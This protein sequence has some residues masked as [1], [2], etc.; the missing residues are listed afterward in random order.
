MKQ[1]LNH[2]IAEWGLFLHLAK[3][4]KYVLQV[5]N[6]SGKETFMH[7][8][9]IEID[10]VITMLLHSEIKIP[11]IDLS[12][13]SRTEITNFINSNIT[14][15]IITRKI[16]PPVLLLVMLEL[17][18]KAEFKPMIIVF[19]NTHVKDFITDF[20]ERILNN[21]S[22][23]KYYRESYTIV[24]NILEPNKKNF[25]DNALLRSYKEAFKDL[26]ESSYN[27]L[28]HGIDHV[29][30][31]YKKALHLNIK[32]NLNI[33]KDEILVASLFH[34]IFQDKDRDK[35]HILAHDWIM[36][37]V[38]PMI[39]LNDKNKQKRIALAIKEHRSTY[40]EKYSSPLSE[41]LATADKETPDINK[42]ITR[43]YK[44]QLDKYPDRTHRE[45][46]D[47]VISHLVEKFGR[48]GYIKYTYIYTMEYC[49]QLSLLYDLIDKI[50]DG[51]IKINIARFK[52]TVRVTLKRKGR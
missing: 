42:I 3:V 51:K 46:V 19:G 12:L 25:R 50:K 36:S 11:G 31:V 43:A 7:P 33:P 10:K 5:A 40:A 34:D 35:H 29:E 28:A 21:D 9:A 14:P 47:N 20:V 16:N 44:Y 41:L 45:M 6:N 17:L 37:S 1:I 23:E 38:H 2:S 4:S 27:S 49:D 15:L 18:Y 39:T 32:Y 48:D 22:L 8:L 52:D 26:L 24:S 30:G 13:T